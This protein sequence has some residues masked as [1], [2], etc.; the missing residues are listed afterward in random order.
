MVTPTILFAKS[1][2]KLLAEQNSTYATMFDTH[3]RD[4]LDAK[5][6]T[7]DISTYL[8]GIHPEH[9]LDSIAETLEHTADALIDIDKGLSY[10]LWNPFQAA[11]IAAF[12]SHL[13]KDV[14]FV[15]QLFEQQARIKPKKKPSHGIPPLMKNFTPEDS[16]L[17]LHRKAAVESVTKELVTTKPKQVTKPKSAVPQAANPVSL[18]VTSGDP[19]PIV[20]PENVPFMDIKKQICSQQKHPFSKQLHIIRC[21]NTQC[22]FCLQASLSI[23]IT[24]CNSIKKHKVGLCHSS[25][26]YPHV[27]PQLWAQWRHTHASGDF[28]N[29]ASRI[30]IVGA[31]QSI[32]SA[33]PAE[34][35]GE[36]TSPI[37]KRTMTSIP[38]E[39]SSVFKRKFAGSYKSDDDC[40]EASE[41]ALNWAAE[42]EYLP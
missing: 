18:P 28:S 34:D 5:L 30:S 16:K 9:V 38:E 10:I 29:C 24:R 11:T 35:I 15:T 17:Q 20:S 26:W 31:V 19:V 23:P 40:S 36:I 4:L 42:V 21:T 25:G 6:R 13:H 32:K 12:K 2:S 39:T 8:H 1:L 37:R 14:H 22:G 33:L 7:A 3:L 41:P 27:T